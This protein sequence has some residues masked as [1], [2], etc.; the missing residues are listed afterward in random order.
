LFSFLSLLHQLIIQLLPRVNHVS[1]QI[2]IP[3]YPFYLDESTC[4]IHPLCREKERM[5]ARGHPCFP[6]PALP[7][8]PKCLAHL[9]FSKA[10][11]SIVGK[12]AV[13]TDYPIRRTGPWIEGK[14]PYY[15]LPIPTQESAC[16]NSVGVF[17]YTPIG[18]FPMCF[19]RLPYF[20]LSFDK[21]SIALV[22]QPGYY[23]RHGFKW[24]C[25]FQFHQLLESVSPYL[26]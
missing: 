1:P 25:E 17:E 6:Y 8:F 23:S 4:E 10:L 19:L 11:I 22:E 13:M 5:V 15:V 12:N 20:W 24:R 14:E 9:L 26:A 21:L 18:L 3:G 16:S 2:A 7:Q